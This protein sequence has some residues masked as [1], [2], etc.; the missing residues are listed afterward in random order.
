[1]GTE[2]QQNYRTMN[3]PSGRDG[4]PPLKKDP[5][6]SPGSMSEPGSGTAAGNAQPLF[7]ANF[8]RRHQIV[9]FL[10]LNRPSVPIRGNQGT[11]WMV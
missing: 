3:F 10:L 9:S 6:R 11:V 1:M 8:E 2:S 7:A 4:R 5:A